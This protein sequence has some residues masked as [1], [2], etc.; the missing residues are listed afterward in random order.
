MGACICSL[1][2]KRHWCGTWGSG[3][4]SEY[5]GLGMQRA[6]LS[7]LLCVSFR[8][9]LTD[10]TV[11]Q[12]C[13]MFHTQAPLHVEH[14]F[15][16]SVS[17]LKLHVL[18][19]WNEAKIF[20]LSQNSWGN[21]EKVMTSAAHGRKKR[22]MLSKYVGYARWGQQ[23][24]REGRKGPGKIGVSKPTARAVLG[25]WWWFPRESGGGKG[26]CWEKGQLSKTYHA[27]HYR[28]NRR[29]GMHQP[30]LTC[31]VQI[32]FSPKPGTS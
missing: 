32:L 28:E 22:K 19:S 31:P 17:Q 21:R 24:P 14:S 9:S 18:D 3:C 10:E 13:K 29:N 20:V 30:C 5:L 27:R 15:C 6:T 8:E 16:K 23:W 11:S 4:P 7:H 26:Q 2:Q 25:L 1:K 12:M